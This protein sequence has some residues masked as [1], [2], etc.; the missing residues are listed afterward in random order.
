M[1]YKY[2]RS[3]EFIATILGG[4]LVIVSF[5]LGAKAG[6]RTSNN[7]NMHNNVINLNDPDVIEIL[8]DMGF[9]QTDNNNHDKVRVIRF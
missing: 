3:N 9:T 5:I 4:V 8:D 6:S 1:I 2:K 7:K